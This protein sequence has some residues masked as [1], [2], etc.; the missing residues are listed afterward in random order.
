MRKPAERRRVAAAVSAFALIAMPMLS[1]TAHASEDQCSEEGKVC[2]WSESSFEGEFKYTS[3]T[4]PQGSC[5][6]LEAHWPNETKSRIHS[7]KNQT[8]YQ[9]E[10]FAEGAKCTGRPAKVLSAGQSDSGVSDS[11]GSFRLAPVCDLD[12]LCLYENADYTGKVWIK[13]FSTG[14]VCYGGADGD[15]ARSV[16][17]N[18][19]YTAQLYPS[20]S[21]CLYKQPS[22]GHYSFRSYDYAVWNFKMDR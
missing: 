4:K 7:V 18:Y 21:N 22:V 10:F 5:F 1:P 19:G 6:G 9:L 15:G 3:F 11:Y 16:Y 8:D 12:R 17:N 20:N 14:N 2:L 13:T